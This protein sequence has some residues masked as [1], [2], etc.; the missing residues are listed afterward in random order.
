MTLFIPM[1]NRN[2]IYELFML[3]LCVYVLIVLASET[4]FQFD[5]ETAQ[6]LL[7]LDNFICVI[8]LLDFSWRLI[9]APSRIEYLKWGWIDFVSSIPTIDVLRIGRLARVIRIIRVL[10]GLRLAKTLIPY[11]LKR[12]SQSVFFAAASLAI[13]MIVFSSIAIL[14]VEVGTNANIKGADDALWW[15]LCTVTPLAP[16]TMGYGDKYPVTSEGRLIAVML[17][18]TGVGL[19]G[20]FTGLVSSWFLSGESK[21]ELKTIQNKLARIE[22][23]LESKSI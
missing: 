10:R 7:Y 1:Q 18:V 2:K 12:R 13:I 15:S 8:F 11:V 20:I 19:F 4:V 17:M 6:I 3:G 14:H 21:D 5:D 22:K 9:T 23:L 16:S